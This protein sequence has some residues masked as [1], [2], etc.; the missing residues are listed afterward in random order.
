MFEKKIIIKMEN[1]N[2]IKFFILFLFVTFIIKLHNTILK[3]SSLEIFQ[4]SISIFI[5]FLENLY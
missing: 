2:R 5:I 1:K 3:H 4:F